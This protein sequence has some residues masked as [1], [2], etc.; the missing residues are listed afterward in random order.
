MKRINLFVTTLFVI[1][2]LAGF[3]CSTT[4]KVAFKPVEVYKTDALRITQISK[5][6][7]IHTSYKQT[8]DFGLVPCNGVIITDKSECIILDTPVNDSCATLLINWV[9]QNLDVT[10]NAIIPTHFHDDC[11]GGLNAFHEQHIPSYAYTR[12]IEFAKQNNITIPEH[13]FSD[14]LELPIVD[15]KIIVKFF[16]EGHTRDNVVAYFPAE[17]ILFGGCLIKSID[18]GKGYLADANTAAWPETVHHVKTAFP[19]VQIVVPGH[20]DYGDQRLL[21]YT[22]KLFSTK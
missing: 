7:Y 17:N 8:D 16:G 15:K 5:H 1:C 12:T 11:I 4:G 22:I 20:G 6:A 3:Q 18:A 13:S 21:D 10:I 14:S 19:E 2:L 9:K